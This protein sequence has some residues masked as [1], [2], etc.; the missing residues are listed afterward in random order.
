VGGPIIAAID[1]AGPAYIATI[2]GASTA[3]EPVAAGWLA[4]WTY[5]IGG[6]AVPFRRMV[7]LVVVEVCPTVTSAELLADYPDLGGSLIAGAAD[8]R[9][10]L[11]TAWEEL[12]RDLAEHGVD[13]H[14]IMDP[15]TLARAHK[16]RASALRY[17]KVGASTQ[18]PDLMT[19]AREIRDEYDD[20]LRRTLLYDADAD[21]AA[22]SKQRMTSADGW[23]V[24]QRRHG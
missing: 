10:D 6:V 11:A 12:D 5:T 19:R 8:L 22:D 1:G 9:A 14:R 20:H 24:V 15:R 7:R 13:L 21:G 4:V 2:P 3:G 18:D 23:D 16:L 17:S